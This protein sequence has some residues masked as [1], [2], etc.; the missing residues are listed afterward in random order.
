VESLKSLARGEL[1]AWIDYYSGAPPSNN[2]SD[3]AAQK[4]LA[5]FIGVDTDLV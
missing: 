2:V 4:A 1:D 3:V 5:A